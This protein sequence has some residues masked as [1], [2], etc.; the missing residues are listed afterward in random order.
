MIMAR[1]V[2]K[3]IVT[4][5]SNAGTPNTLGNIMLYNIKDIV[6]SNILVLNIPYLLMI[7]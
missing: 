2:E 7:T 5:I 6:F 3:Y 4:H 1:T